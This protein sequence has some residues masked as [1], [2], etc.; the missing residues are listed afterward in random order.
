MAY[1]VTSLIQEVKTLAKDTS[2]TDGLITGWLQETQDRVL[3][4]TR[5][6]FLEVVGVQ[7][8][9][10]GDLTFGYWADLQTILSLTLTFNSVAYRP[11]Y[12]AYQTFDECFPTPSNSGRSLPSH[13]T[14]YGRQLYW[15]TPLDKAYGITM[16]YLREPVR[17]SSG[18]IVPDI[19]EEY[20]Q[21]LIKGALAGVEE[22]RENFDIAALHNRK[23]EDLAEDLI[24]RYGLR[25][26][27]APHK[28][29]TSRRG[30]GA[31]W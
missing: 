30:A 19:P 8:L 12:L 13:F 9:V 27:T 29:R 15:S 31:A 23:V 16:R 20:K 24:G 1:N 22:Y 21:I 25:Q 28:V 18:A 10:P 3:G 26:L 7:T 4:R 14:D 6:P 2:L 5:F 17:L 11:D